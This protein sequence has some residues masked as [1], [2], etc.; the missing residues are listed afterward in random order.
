MIVFAI[1]GVAAGLVYLRMQG[2]L[3]TAE[4]VAAVLILL[5]IIP[6]NIAVLR[7]GVKR[8]ERQ[9]SLRIAH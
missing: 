3:D 9:K 8:F 1:V 5:A 4:I 7:Y 2:P 6:P